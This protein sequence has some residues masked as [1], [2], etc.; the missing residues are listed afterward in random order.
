M[1]VE[2]RVMGGANLEDHWNRGSREGISRGSWDYIVLQQGPSSLPESRVDLRKWSIE[3]ANEVR[4][5]GAKPALY[6][7]WP[8]QGQKDGFT[9][10]SRSYREAAAASES[11]ILPAGEA[12]AEAL[13]ADPRL[14]LY[15]SDH[16]HPTEAG[17]Y[18]AS[19]V[20]AHRLGR[21]R[22]ESV[23]ESLRLVGGRN[24]SIPTPIAKRLREAAS[25]VKNED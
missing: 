18:L 17:T 14:S 11:Q 22:L 7:V 1:R 2:S 12:W 24:V 3:W 6:M 23:P 10:V 21:V 4:R 9:L 13:R 25:R 19:L 16:L 5:A 20:I 15:Q 8:Y